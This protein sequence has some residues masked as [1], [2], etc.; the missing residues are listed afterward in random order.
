VEW[1]KTTLFS[2]ALAD[3]KKRGKNWHKIKKKEECGTT[4]KTEDTLT[5]NLHEKNAI[6]E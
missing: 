2:Q 1:H 5:I 4:E 3:S 6:S